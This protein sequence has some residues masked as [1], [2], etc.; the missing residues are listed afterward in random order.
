MKHRLALTSTFILCVWYSTEVLAGEPKLAT[1]RSGKRTTIVG[2]DS[3]RTIQWHR[4]HSHIGRPRHH[5]H[6]HYNRFYYSYRHDPR[7]VIV[8]TP[9][10]RYRYHAPVTVVTSEP[11]YC[12][13]H[14]V[15]FVSRAGF[16]DHTAGAHR[17]PLQT[18]DGICASGNASCVIEGY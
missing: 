13:V 8:I 10:S 5:Y 17:I 3:S 12:H 4:R 14:H 1:S 18:A 11:F 16:L 2:I 6:R 15:G 9:S 7:S